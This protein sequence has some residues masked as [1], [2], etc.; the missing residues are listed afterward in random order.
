VASWP[1]ATRGMTTSGWVSPTSLTFQ[2]LRKLAQRILGGGQRRVQLGHCLLVE[3]WARGGC[4][5]QSGEVLADRD[6]HRRWP[7]AH[8]R[9]L[10]SKGW[11]Y[12][13]RADD[14]NERGVTPA[15]G[16]KW[17]SASVRKAIQAA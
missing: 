15:R 1:V 12:N 3:W 16:A 5:L 11:S 14:L 9:R 6:E 7:R 10:R 8:L 4:R 13:R 2:R 17:Y